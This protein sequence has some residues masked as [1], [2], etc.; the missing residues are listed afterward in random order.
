MSCCSSRK[1]CKNG[2]SRS[3][4]VANFN[5]VEKFNC[6]LFNDRHP[7]VI[8]YLK[9][10]KPIINHK[11]DIW[12]VG[13]NIQKKLVAEAKNSKFLDQKYYY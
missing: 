9:K 8:T 4:I 11:F 5:G 6:K 3:K 10:E 2:S 7:Q 12:Q 13:K 1:F